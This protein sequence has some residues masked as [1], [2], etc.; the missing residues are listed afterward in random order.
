[1]RQLF[2]KLADFLLRSSKR[3]AA[4]TPAE[5]E[6]P[7]IPKP[8][9]K[10]FLEAMRENN[11][12]RIVEGQ[13]SDSTRDKYGYYCQNIKNYLRA[14][15]LDEIECQDVRIPVFEGLRS[16]L[17]TN[18][19]S[20]G[21]SHSSRH[22]EMCIS[23]MDYA[24]RME[25]ASHNPLASLET[26]R[27]K[28]KAVV[29]L[30][31]KELQKFIKHDFKNAA[32]KRVQILYTFQCATGISYANLYDYQ[33]RL[34]EESG[35]L[36]IEDNRKKVGR[37]PFY[38]PLDAPGFEIAKAIHTAFEGHLPHL[39]NASYNRYLK[40]M[41]AILNINKRLTT[42]TARKTF[43]TL[44]DQEGFSLGVISS[45]LGNSEDVC[46]KHYIQGSKKKVAKEMAEKYDRVHLAIAN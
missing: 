45:I 37:T 46:K 39:E 33:T 23:A 2:A 31:A 26:G 32:F 34:D 27:D 38:V 7:E 30:D 21:K 17:H 16:W 11:E 36:W 19:K 5:T 20:C 28:R 15:Q 8:T 40:E 25:W 4:Q 43:A 9:G 3:K 6:V 29:H 18:L 1:M 10:L 44:M 35:G 12:R 41:A 42:H 22:I 24:V 13:L 14:K